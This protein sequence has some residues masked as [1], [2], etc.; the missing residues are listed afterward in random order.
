V[1]QLLRRQD[2]VTADEIAV[3]LSLE[4]GPTAALLDYVHGVDDLLERDA[5]EHYSLSQF[6]RAIV[7]RFSSTA[8]AEASINMFDLRVGAYGPV[9]Q[10]L[11]NLLTGASRYGEDVHRNGEYAEDAVGKLAMRFWTSLEHHL[12]EREVS[13]ALEVGLTTPLLKEI[14]R[15]RPGIRLIGLDRKPDAIDQGV[16]EAALAGVE[17]GSWICADFFDVDRWVGRLPADARGLIFSLHFH[18]LT[19]QGSDRLVEALRALRRAIPNWALL[20]LEQPLLPAEDRSKVT[21]TLWLYSQSNVLIHHL[22]GNGRILS[23]DAWIDVGRRAGC[24]QVSDRPCN[25][26]GYRAFLFEF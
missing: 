24:S 8:D 13:C 18:E 20:A 4:P 10:Q 23:R 17:V 15:R 16:A 12:A 3:E 21:D 11:G 25:Y 1:L 6:G 2:S 22:I 19:A 5:D 26:L 7:E 14:G 9:W